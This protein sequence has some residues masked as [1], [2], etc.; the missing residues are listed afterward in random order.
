MPVPWYGTMRD[1]PQKQQ[2]WWGTE[3]PRAGPWAQVLWS[4]PAYRMLGHFVFLVLRR[5]G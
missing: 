1:L 2:L 3:D 4:T 5:D